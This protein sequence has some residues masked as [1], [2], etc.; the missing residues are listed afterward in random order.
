M[1]AQ[2]IGDHQ[3]IP[4]YGHPVGHRRRMIVPDLV[5]SL[6]PKIIAAGLITERELDELDGAARAIASTPAH[7]RGRA[8]NNPR[9]YEGEYLQRICAADVTSSMMISR[10]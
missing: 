10:R 2:A 7:D 6:R 8:N 4:G 3:S 9:S 5:R 1:R